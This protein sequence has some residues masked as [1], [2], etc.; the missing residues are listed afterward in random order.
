MRR[1]FSFFLVLQL[2]LGHAPA[3]AKTKTPPA[4]KPFLTAQSYAIVDFSSGSILHSRMPH[5][6][7]PPASTAKVMTVLVVMKFLPLDYPVT[8][9]RNAVNVSPSK[10]GLTLGARYRAIDLVKACLVSSSNDA[11]VALA[12]AVAGSEREFAK[13]MNERA[14]ELGMINTN[15]V[16]STGL[17][18]K[19][20]PQYTTAFDLTKMMRQAAKE[21]RVDEMMGLLETTISGSDGKTLALRAHNKMLWKAP[22]SIKGK[23]GWTYA[24][25]HTFVGTDYARHKSIAFALLSS[26]KPW[27]DIQ[28]LSAFGVV[29]VRRR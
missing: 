8:V 1:L 28:R 5:K 19:K 22:K 24:S 26:N 2:V 9:G 17:T 20:K 13:L 29:L 3:E 18:D 15:F 7:L 4:P 11:A 14:K 25:R 27:T 21:R 16:N 10:A 12:E 23:T 6:R